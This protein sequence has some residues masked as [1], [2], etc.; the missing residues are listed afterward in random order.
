[1]ASGVYNIFKSELM[2]AS[3]DLA[4]DNIKVALLTSDHDFNADSTSNSEWSDVSANEVVG[5][6]YTTGGQSLA[7]KTVTVDNS[8]DEG[9]FDAADVNWPAS[10]ITARHAVIY[11]DTTTPKYII[12]SIDFGQNTS[13]TNGNFQIQWDAEGIINLN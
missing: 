3:I 13:S 4:N 12:A 1:M 7:S 11:D 10:T 9:V 2:K 5:V 8:D 6:N